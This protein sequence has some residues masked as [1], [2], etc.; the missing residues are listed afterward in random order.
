MGGLERRVRDM[1]ENSHV[2]GAFELR[3]FMDNLAARGELARIEKPVSTKF[4]IGSLARK[5]EIQNGPALF[6]ENPEGYGVPVVVDLLSTSK[7]LA[8]G[9]GV[10]EENVMDKITEAMKTP[11]KPVTVKHSRVKERVFERDA[12]LLKI[13]PI[14]THSEL[15][16]G[17]YI[18]GGVVFAKDPVTGRQ[19]LSFHRMQVK[20]P[21]KL[22]IDIDPWRHLMEFFDNS[23]DKP[24]EVAICIGLPP[25]IEIGAAVRVPFDEMEMAGSLVGRP[26]E[27]VQCDHVDV[28]VPACTEIL[29]EGRIMHTK[30]MEGPFAEFTGYYGGEKHPIVK[31]ESISCREDAVYRTICGGSLEH[32]LLGNVITRDPLL[33]GF[34]RHVC[35]GV[36]AVHHP[37]EA[38]GFH[39]VVSIK[40]TKEGEAK[41]VIFAA[42]TSHVNLKQV[43]VVDDDID[44]YDPKDVEWAVATRVQGDE[45][46]IVIPGALG[47]VLDKSTHE[48][49][50]AKVGIDATIPLDRKKDFVRVKYWNLDKIDLDDYL[51]RVKHG[52]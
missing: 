22:G 36:K 27:V 9:I 35:S 10:P 46:I 33:Y 39:A 6:F 24:L 45:D 19:N 21:K 48:G 28:Q 38:A 52:R 13:L 50:S 12:N 7:R 14:P 44:I 30:E 42:L 34:V 1:S 47:H 2:K 16:G 49:V 5:S 25:A 18:S 4:V 51:P 37:P 31:V 26:F 40:K 8:I 17:P 32:I 15:D 11:L 3:E 29:I 20:G 41:N 43:I 23:K